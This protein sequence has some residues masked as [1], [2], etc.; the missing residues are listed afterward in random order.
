MLVALYI[1]A[2]LFYC[3]YIVFGQLMTG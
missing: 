3:S 2:V 1:H